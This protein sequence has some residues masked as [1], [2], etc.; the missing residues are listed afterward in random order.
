MML[1]LA[2]MVV[3]AQFEPGV[4]LR[5]TPLLYAVGMVLLVAV[6]I[7][8]RDR[9]GLAALARSAGAAAI[10]AVGNH[11][12]RGAADGCVVLQRTA[13]A[14][15]VQSSVR[16]ACDHRRAG[17]IDRDST[18]PRHRHSGGIGWARGDR[19]RRIAVALDRT[20]HRSRRGCAA[21]A[22]VRDARL[23]ARSRADAVRSGARSARCRLEHHSVDNGDRVWR[24]VRQRVS[25][26]A[27]SRTSISCRKDRPTSS[28]QWLPRN[29][30]S[31][32]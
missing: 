16:R 3:A 14:A 22:L 6:D 5:W 18:R 13:V 1:A 28:S 7:R 10:S 15:E 11:A 30:G 23:P 26:K 32:A 24:R 17:C 21:R 8:R 27:R 19:A 29:S 31:S 25:S 2:I 12:D 9:Q 20:C 4:Y